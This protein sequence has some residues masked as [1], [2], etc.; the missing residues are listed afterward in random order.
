L[1]PLGDRQGGNRGAKPLLAEAD[2]EA[3]RERLNTP[4]DGGLWSSRGSWIAARPG[5]AHVHAPCG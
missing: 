5:R 2:L 3:L 4:D 1:I